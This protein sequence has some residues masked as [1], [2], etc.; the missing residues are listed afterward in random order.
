MKP[1]ESIQNQSKG[2]Q[3]GISDDFILNL[4]LGLKSLDSAPG[5]E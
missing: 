4:G 1:T 5:N 3:A 2:A